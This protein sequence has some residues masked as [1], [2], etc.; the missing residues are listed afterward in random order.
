MPPG[1]FK[2]LKIV[3][4]KK[5]VENLQNKSVKEALSANGFFEKT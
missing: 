3:F 2:V 1:S 5:S 4:I